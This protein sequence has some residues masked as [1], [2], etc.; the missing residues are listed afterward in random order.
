LPWLPDLR[1]WAT[2]AARCLRG[3]G[4]LHVIEFH[5]FVDMLGEDGKSIE[6]P[7]FESNE[8]L[9]SRVRGSYAD[10]AAQFEHEAYEWA[11]SLGETLGALLAAG[12]RI[13]S[14]TEYPYS[15]YN[16]F[17]FLEEVGPD[18]WAVRGRQVDIPLTFALTAVKPK[19]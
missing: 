11:H 17:P 9:R 12:L 1:S 6:R 4:E 8:P 7:Y 10:P 16:C 18:R 19:A 5:P 13:T 2:S 3:G 14:F 15:P